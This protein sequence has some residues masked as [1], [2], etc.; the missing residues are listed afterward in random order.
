MNPIIL[1]FLK[2]LKKNNNR[3][4]F[5]ANKGRYEE[6]KAEF[7]VF[8]NSVIH[9]IARFDNTV[10]FIDA[11]DCQFRIYRDVRFSKNKE[12]YKTNF[13]AWMTKD[14]RKSPGPGY[15]FHMSPGEFFL[16]GGIHMPD[17]ELLKRIRQEIYYNIKEFRKILENKEF[18]KYFD[19]IDEWDKGKLPPKGFPA[20]FPD[21]DLLK[22]KSF[23]V[24]YPFDEKLLS[25]D[26][27]FK[28]AIT[29]YKAMLPYNEFMR[30][31]VQV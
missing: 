19:G 11:K 26:K 12:P 3:E 10:S 1:K 8:I 30:K 25:S 23:T 29:V 15:Y 2:D 4:W 7:E 20:D 22:N 24:S 31:A 28:T 18:K 16:S 9:E 5:Q 6:A 14:G 13:G 17:P 27:L 21:I